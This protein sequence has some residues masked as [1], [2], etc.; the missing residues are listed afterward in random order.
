[1]FPSYLMCIFF[2]VIS[3]RPCR[4]PP[5]VSRRPVGTV[6]PSRVRWTGT[7]VPSCRRTSSRV[8]GALPTAMVARRHSTV[9]TTLPR[10]RNK[11]SHQAIDCHC[12]EIQSFTCS[13]IKLL[14]NNLWLCIKDCLKFIFW[15]IVHLWTFLY[16]ICMNKRK[17]LKFPMNFLF[18]QNNGCGRWK[19]IPSSVNVHG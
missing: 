18:D 15:W 14:W 17:L 11:V 16:S 12:Q 13:Y 3:R 2:I 9:P 1:M 4:T 10:T 7:P 19:N 8:C 6:S 5:P